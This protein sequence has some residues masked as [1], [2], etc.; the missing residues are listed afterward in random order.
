MSYQSVYGFPCVS[1]PNDFSPD[2]ECCS[3]AELEAHRLA[4]QT[5]GKPDHVPNRGCTTEHDEGG[6]FVRHVLRTS[7]GIGVNS[8]QACDGCGEP[9]DALTTCHDCGGHLDFCEV[10][11]PEHAKHTC[12]ERPKEAR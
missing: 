2:A 8:I 3:P 6:Q 10:C 12:P 5:F 1:D 9:G 7:W 11:W 4:C